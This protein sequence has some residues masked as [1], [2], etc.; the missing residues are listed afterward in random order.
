[1]ARSR[2]V[3]QPETKAPAA[4]VRIDQSHRLATGNSTAENESS[5]STNSTLA[6]SGVMLGAVEEQVL[7]QA[8]QLASV[9]QS[10]LHDLDRRESNLHAA[11]AKFE[12]EARSIRLSMQEREAILEEGERTWDVKMAEWRE[13][14]QTQIEREERLVTLEEQLQA[15]DSQAQDESAGLELARRTLQVERDE[16]QQQMQQE[17]EEF[18]QGMQRERD[19]FQ[20]Q[21]QQER[22]A[23]LLEIEMIRKQDREQAEQ[24]Q[25]E[26]QADIER[27]RQE[28]FAD[29]EEFEKKLSAFEQ[30]RALWVVARTGGTQDAFDLAQERMQLENDRQAFLI[31]RREFEAL[32]GELAWEL[33]RLRKAAGTAATAG[34]GELVGFT[35]DAD[36]VPAAAFIPAASNARPTSEAMAALADDGAAEGDVP[37]SSLGIEEQRHRLEEAADY[38]AREAEDLDRERQQLTEMQQRWKERMQQQHDELVQRQQTLESEYDAKRVKLAARE[39]HFDQQMTTVEQTRQDILKVHRESLEMR[40]VAEELWAQVTGKVPAAEASQAIAKLRNRLATQFKVENQQL[41][42]KKQQILELAERLNEQY[43]AV[44]RQRRELQAWGAAR[45]VEIE[46]QA[47]RLVQREVELDEQQQLLQERELEWTREVRRL[48]QQVRTQTVRAA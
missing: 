9:L 25:I 34:D 47:E 8:A 19:E 5:R 1:M 11:T 31:E 45:Q 6:E 40:L 38:L 41:A 7:A 27:Q 18:Q 20:Q 16:F 37:F 24:Q 4:R 42:T 14:F 44:L 43:E 15:R 30:E 36:Y 35:S 28:L 46:Q 23:L 26:L 39:K 12:A 48:Q 13:R 10:R 2:I 22:D 21:T 29:R 17:R 33:D 3:D 32:R